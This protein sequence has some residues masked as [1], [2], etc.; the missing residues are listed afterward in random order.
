[1]NTSFLFTQEKTGC[2]F[3]AYYNSCLWQRDKQTYLYRPITRTLSK[4][5]NLSQCKG[6]L[7]RGDPV[8]TSF[9]FLITYLSFLSLCQRKYSMPTFCTLF[10]LAQIS[11]LTFYPLYST[12]A[13]LLLIFYIYFLTSVT[14]KA[15][16]NPSFFLFFLFCSFLSVESPF[17]IG[18]SFFL[19]F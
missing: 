15:A 1:M 9:A 13:F 18:S 12:T 14:S 19:L 16:R 10:C 4:P 8:W 17:F 7:A 5:L 2:K 3:S 6:S 11:A